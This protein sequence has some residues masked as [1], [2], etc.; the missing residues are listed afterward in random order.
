MTPWRRRALA[1]AGVAALARLGAWWFAP[2]ESSVAAAVPATAAALPVAAGAAASKAA[3][4]P[5]GAP[6]SPLGEAERRTRQAQWR[7][8]LERAQAALAAYEQAAKYPHDSRPI[9][10]HPDQLRPFVPIA[11]DRALRQPGGT[12]AQGMHLKTTQERIFLAGDETARITLTLQDDGGRTLPLRVTRAVLHE[13]TAPGKTAST[14]EFAVPVSD[15]GGG[16][17]AALLHPAAQGFAGYAGLVRLDLNLEY[18]GQPGFIYFDL[19]YS[20]EQAATWLP[21]VRDVL[22]GGSLAFV[23]KADVQIAGRYLVSAR[24]D[25]AN[26]QPFA[27]ALFN[28]EVG[29]GPHELRL[30]VFGKLIRDRQ[31]VFPLRLRDIEAFL[32]KPDSYPDRVMLP[33]L[34]GVQHSSKI[35]PLASFSDA[36]WASEEH[37]RYVAEL[38][39]DIDEA[40]AQLARL[41]P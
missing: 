41:G 31:P 36:P 38:S 16:V 8:R 14:P 20:P 18:A 29:R 25:D 9:E 21:G 40:Q 39:K 13:V 35:Y 32:L 37:A 23:V 4:A 1:L 12:A 11:E 6:L 7:G 24:V 15:T 17:L 26:G 34:A 30:P 33:R 10:E 5:A 3:S 27:L 28:D 22:T 2:A 19:I